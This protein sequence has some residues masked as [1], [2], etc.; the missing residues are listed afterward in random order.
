MFSQQLQVQEA[1]H[2]QEIERQKKKGG[3]LLVDLVKLVEIVISPFLG[4]GLA[5]FRRKSEAA[6]ADGCGRE[7]QRAGSECSV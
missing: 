1:D 2:S 4:K 3:K 7:T 6:R 5:T